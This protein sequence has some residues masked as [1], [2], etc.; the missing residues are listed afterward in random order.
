MPSGAR[1]AMFAEVGAEG[2]VPAD[3]GPAENADASVTV[4]IGETALTARFA[5]RSELRPGGT[6]WLATQPARLSLFDARTRR[7]IDRPLAAG[8]WR[9]APERS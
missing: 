7:R 9:R 3:V 2:A 5:G 6:A 1:T 4:R 8:R